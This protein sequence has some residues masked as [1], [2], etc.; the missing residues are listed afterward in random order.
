MVGV[1][2]LPDSGATNRTSTAKSCGL[3]PH[4]PAGYFSMKGLV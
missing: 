2:M 1:V 3:S 4:D